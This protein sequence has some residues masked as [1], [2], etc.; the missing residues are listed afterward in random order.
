MP[1]SAFALMEGMACRYRLM[2]DGRRQILAFIVPGDICD[3]HAILLRKVDHSICTIAPTTIASIA[4]ERLL[5]VMAHFPRINMALWWT[6]LQDEAIQ[7]EHIV[8]LGRR[9]AHSRVAYLLCELVWR[10][11]ANGLGD[12]HAIRLPMTQSEIADMLGLTPVHVNRVLQDFRKEGV[13]SLDHHHL[14]LLDSERLEGIAELTQDYLH[15][16][17]ASME[18]ERQFVRWEGKPAKRRTP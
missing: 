10:Q 5:D 14:L 6:A 12:D 17:G 7:R 1:R 13:I 2:A 4:R 16:N 9:N 11:M 15:L 8:A 18:I 3:I